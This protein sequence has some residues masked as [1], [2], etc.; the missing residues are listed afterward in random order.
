[1][2]RTL[3]LILALHTSLAGDPIEQW[4]DNALKEWNVPGAA[5]AI[6]EGD[7]LILARGYGVIN[8]ESGAKVNEDTIFQL[9]SITKA[10][11]AAAIGVQVDLERL[12]WDDLVIDHLPQ[13]ALKEPYPTRFA[14]ARDLLA[15]RTGLP[16]FGGDLMGKIGYTD[17]EIMSRIRFIVPASSFRN[18]PHYS[19]LGYF[20]AGELLKA[21]SGQPFDQAVQATLLTPLDMARSGFAEKLMDQNTASPHAVV[22]GKLKVVP[23]DPTGGFPAAGAMTSTARD[24]AIW[25]MMLLSGGQN[26]LKEKTIRDMFVSSMSGTPEFSEAPPIDENSGFNFGLGWDNYH[27]NGALIVEKGGGLDGIRTVTTLIPEKKLGITILCNRNLTLF[28]EAVRAFFLEQ[29]L[30]KASYDVQK[31]I[32]KSQKE[33]DQLLAPEAPTQNPLPAQALD[34]YTGDFKNSLYSPFKI[35]AENNQLFALVGP[36]QYKGTLKHDS[37]NTYLLSWPAINSGSERVTFVIGPDGKAFQIETETLG[38]LT[39]E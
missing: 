35:I 31:A 22:N 36:A 1:M 10:F 17:E 18:S 37:G 25:M 29:H 34:T 2:I 33:L 4:I 20:A 38:T 21:V 27:F 11:T 28:P 39:T 15:H 14:T 13:F 8:L 23:S 7:T 6:V 9:A 5:V 32:K 19:N 16:A 3:I 30:G 26:I 24:M 12:T